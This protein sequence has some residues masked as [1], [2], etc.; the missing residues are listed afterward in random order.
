MKWPGWQFIQTDICS[1][2]LDSYSKKPIDHF[3]IQ[4]DSLNSRTDNIDNQVDSMAD[5]LDSQID[6]SRWKRRQFR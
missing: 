1:K 2:Q 3:D 4:T 6:M 5:S